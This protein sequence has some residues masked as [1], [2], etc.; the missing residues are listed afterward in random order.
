M[1]VRHGYNCLELVRPSVAPSC[2]QFHHASH[3]KCPNDFTRIPLRSSLMFVTID[4]ELSKNHV[5]A[6]LG[7]EVHKASERAIDTTT[8]FLS[9]RITAHRNPSTDYGYDE[10]Q[11]G[12][13]SMEER[14]G[15]MLRW[16][17]GWTGA[18]ASQSSLEA[19]R[20]RIA[21]AVCLLSVINK[22]PLRDQANKPA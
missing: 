13:D 19:S 6:P 1:H 11:G 5:L 3:V 14:E 8:N 2:A 18:W 7:L 10:A 17:D 12:R 9:P 4:H 21:R 16:K 22:P 20:R 15:R